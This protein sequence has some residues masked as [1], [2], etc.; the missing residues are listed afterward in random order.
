[1]NEAWRKRMIFG[2]LVVAVI[3]GYFSLFD[4]KTETAPVGP[5]AEPLAGDPAPSAVAAK[6]KI[7]DSLLAT[8]HLAAWG[9]DPFNRDPLA[10]SVNLTGET[11]TLHLLGILYRQTGAQALINGRVIGEG[12]IVEGYRVMSINRENVIVQ[13]AGR[14]VVLRVGKEAS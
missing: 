4:H 14:T 3:W 12:D 11:P 8:Y 2:L 1:M 5:Q 6:S 10:I 7:T 9:S 13:S